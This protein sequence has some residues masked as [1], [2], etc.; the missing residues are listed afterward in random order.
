MTFLLTTRKAPLADE[1]R[2]TR[3]K[4]LSPKRIAFRVNDDMPRAP[5]VIISF[6]VESDT[7]SVFGVAVAPLGRNDIVTGFK[8]GAAHA[9]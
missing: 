1:M 3:R 8:D 5:K 9:L 7:P 2:F 6:F 4:P